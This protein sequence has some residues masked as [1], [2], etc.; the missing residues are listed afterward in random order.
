MPC[1]RQQVRILMH[2]KEFSGP[3]VCPL[4]DILSYFSRKR[5]SNTR[6]ARLSAVNV[7]RSRDLGCEFSM[8]STRIIRRVTINW[9]TRLPLVPNLMNYY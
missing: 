8:Y 2:D 6:E 4:N 9:A 7:C 1:E 3:K 5:C